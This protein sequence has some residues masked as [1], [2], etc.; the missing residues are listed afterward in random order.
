MRPNGNLKLTSVP[1]VPKQYDIL[2]YNP[3][4]AADASSGY[5]PPKL[6]R[7]LRVGAEVGEQQ[8][9]SSQLLDSI[10]GIYIC[11]TGFDWVQEM[12]S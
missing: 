9:M 2:G 1:Q 4:S 8:S 11:T 6:V 3:H 10:K 7:P 12:A 5:V